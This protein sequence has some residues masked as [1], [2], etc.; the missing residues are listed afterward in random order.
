M[1]YFDSPPEPS[2][3]PVQA[4]PQNQWP[5]PIAWLSQQYSTL[6]DKGVG[7]TVHRLISGSGGD[8]IKRWLYD[9]GIECGCDDRQAWLNARFPYNR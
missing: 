7:D 3:R 4:A 9:L 6:E 5:Y 8:V 2:P 1:G